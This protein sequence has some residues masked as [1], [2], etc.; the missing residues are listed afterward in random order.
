[1]NRD[2]LEAIWNQEHVERVEVVMKE[3]VSCEGRDC[4]RDTFQKSRNSAKV[5]I[6]GKMQKVSCLQN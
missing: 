4:F 5:L 2:Q 6:P 1:M 3:S